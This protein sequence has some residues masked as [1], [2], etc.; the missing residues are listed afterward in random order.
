M[1]TGLIYHPDF[2]KH[3]TGHHPENKLRLTKTLEYLDKIGLLNKLANIPFDTANEKD[4]EL[5]HSREQIETVKNAYSQ[6]INL[7]DPDTPICEKSFSIALLA[8]GGVLKAVKEAA[9]GKLKN[10]FCL[11]RP[12][13]HHSTPSRS[14]GFCLFNNVAIAAR[15]LQ[16]NLDHQR[17]LIIDWDAHHGNGTQEA[18]YN[19]PSVLYF[20]T[21]HYPFYP[22]TGSSEEKG[23]KSG[24]GYNINVPL[25]S[26]SGDKEYVSAFEKILVPAA[27]NFKPE[28]IL[29]SAGFD[30]HIEDPLGGMAVTDEGFKTLTEITLDIA[31]KY[32][33]NKI[34][35]V[36]E[37]GYNLKTLPK[38]IAAHLEVLI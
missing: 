17:I 28:F 6:G 2:L 11:V 5:I 1:R 16:K 21:H 13:G 25:S 32:C 23:S 9:E 27:E 14:M 22:G 24:F 7:L 3:D 10:A 20:S 12:P 38:T 4:L 8:V 33:N 26:G 18:F 31:D 29:I 19:D 15:Y 34:V 36:L 35:S 37:G 30:A